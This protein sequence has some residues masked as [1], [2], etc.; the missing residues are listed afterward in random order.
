[1]VP[2]ISELSGQIISAYLSNHD[3]MAGKVRYLN[4]AVTTG[5][6][7]RNQT[8]EPVKLEPVVPIRKNVFPS[9]IVCLQDG[10]KFKM[11]KRHLMTSYGMTPD[12]YRALWV[13]LTNTQWLLRTMPKSMGGLAKTFRVARD[14][15]ELII[16]DK[17][18]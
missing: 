18:L 17:L 7:D 9:Y 10:R 5:L 3:V 16:D 8:L 6:T 13:C 12:Q 4:A 14:R 15:T 1:L 2:T 11:L